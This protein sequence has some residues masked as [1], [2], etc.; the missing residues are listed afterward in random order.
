MD[1][2]YQTLCVRSLLDCGFRVL[3]INHAD[4]IPALAAGYP[5]VSFIEAT[6]DA[7]AIWGRR[8]PYI[9]D[10]LHA[11]MNA[12]E[13]VAGIVN[14]D[15]VFEPSQ[16]WRTWLPAAAAGGLVMG[17]RHD[18]TSLSDGTFRKYYWGFD[19][20]FFPLGAAREL[21]DSAMPFAMGIAW[22]DYWL[23]AALSMR[24][25]HVLTLERPAIAHLIHKDP[26][27]DESWRQAAIRF[28]QF[29][30]REAEKSRGPLPP[31]VR[32]VLPICAEL[33]QMPELRWRN[34]GADGLISQIAVRF[35]PAITGDA[36]RVDAADE[37]ETE[38]SSGTMTPS[39]VFRGFS[40][41]LSAGEALESAKRLEHDGQTVEARNAFEQALLRTPRDHDVLCTFGEYKLRNGDPLGAAELLRR[42]IE[43][44]PENGRP[45]CSLALAL[46]Q[47]GA[48]GEAVN[49]LKKALAERPNLADVAELL[50]WLRS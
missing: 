23:P 16:A 29:I 50:R 25:R 10:L 31:A 27:L 42:G 48:T 13:P 37:S 49:V 32:A 20:F 26:M 4:E 8:T 15:V 1:S 45:Y 21:L 17:Q 19:C 44:D 35:I 5:Q 33:A 41:R 7:S 2:E 28:A 22:W 24:G 18:A 39:R 6:R 11:L 3:S 47:S 9:A 43:T 12:P 36:Q 38:S 30:M 46:N 40:E 14:S 34:R